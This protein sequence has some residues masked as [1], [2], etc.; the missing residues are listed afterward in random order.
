MKIYVLNVDY[1]GYVNNKRGVAHYRLVD[2][3]E[4]ALKAQNFVDLGINW[5][6]P[7]ASG[8]D[9]TP[10]PV[11]TADPRAKEFFSKWRNHFGPA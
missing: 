1:N 8:M 6:A 3:E 4:D 5:A 2:V 9:T 11:W 7:A 10:Y